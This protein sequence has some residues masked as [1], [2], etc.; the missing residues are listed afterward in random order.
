MQENDASP[1]P[2]ILRDIDFGEPAKQ[3]APAYD[4]DGLVNEISSVID[5]VQ[6]RER[7]STLQ[8]LLIYGD[9][10]KINGNDNNKNENINDK[11]EN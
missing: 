5:Y 6:Y 4:I 2:D 7:N 1:L 10:N 9:E 3:E 11:D 8:C